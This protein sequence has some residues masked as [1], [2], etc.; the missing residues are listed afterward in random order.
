MIGIRT[1][2][3]QYY[4]VHFQDISY[5]KY[6][7]LDIPGINSHFNYCL[8]NFMRLEILFCQNDRCDDDNMSVIDHASR[9]TCLG[10][11]GV[12]YAVRV[13]R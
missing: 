7:I 6:I 9:M 11:V 3:H 1:I 8:E 10:C 4:A 12:S 2:L 13:M 5:G